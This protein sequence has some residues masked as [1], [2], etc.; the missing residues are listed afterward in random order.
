MPL[1][2]PLLP[3][4]AAGAGIATFSTMDALMK[5]AS[6]LAGV[7]DALLWRN[8][9]G[10][11][12]GLPLWLAAGRG[13]PDAARLRVH[14]LRSAV[15]AAMALLFFWGLVRTPMAEAIALSFIAP[16]IALYLAAAFLGETVRPQA[17]AASLL[18]IGGVG[19]IVLAR[20]TGPAADQ[21]SPAG[22]AAILASA[23]LYAGNL[24][25]QRRQAQLAGPLEIAFFQSALVGLLLVPAAPW[26]AFAPSPPA[27][28]AIAAAA[29][30]AL[31]SL[32]LLSWGYARAEAQALVP[33][34]YS[35]FVW[36]ALMGWLVF[37]EAV[38]ASTLAGAALIVLGCWIA[39]RGPRAQ[40]ELG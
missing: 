32:V 3:F 23:V 8:L 5:R 22:V 21:G 4:L 10:A 11:L 36:A 15:V 31:L 35:A 16:L 2:H 7:Y 9:A 14:L 33:I 1:R 12:L 28:V 24:V 20:V 40:A 37:G 34:E 30:L 29:V 39:T 6:G 17:I 18:G 27:L 38:T 26:L 13:L 19:V 25:L